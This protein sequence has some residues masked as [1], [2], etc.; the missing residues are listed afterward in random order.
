MMM[1]R[2]GHI[3]EVN[4][5]LIITSQKKLGKAHDGMKPY[6]MDTVFWSRRRALGKVMSGFRVIL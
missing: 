1:I 4:S 5:E 6:A 2:T 3:C